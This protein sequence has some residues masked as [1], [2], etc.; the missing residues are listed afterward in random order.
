[1]DTD[2]WALIRRSAFSLEQ[3]SEPMDV[4]T[5]EDHLNTT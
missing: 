2:L 1:M 5:D 3:V 4:D